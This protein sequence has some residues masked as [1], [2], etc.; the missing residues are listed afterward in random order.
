MANNDSTS[1]VSSGSGSGLPIHS[2]SVD[3]STRKDLDGTV[4]RNAVANETPRSNTRIILVV[5]NDAEG[6]FERLTFD[7]IFEI[8]GHKIAAREKDN[9]HPP[10]RFEFHVTMTVILLDTTST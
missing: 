10:A 7:G 5:Q 6:I 2:V 4:C 9:G 3:L 1:L 8:G